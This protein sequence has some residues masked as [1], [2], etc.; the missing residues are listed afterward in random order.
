[1]TGLNKILALVLLAQMGLLAWAFWP[2]ARDNDDAAQAPLLALGQDSTSRVVISDNETGV[3][4]A[5]G[6]SGWRLPEYH[7]LPVDQ[8][9]FAR[10][11]DELPALARG[12][13]LAQTRAAKIR[14][15]VSADN[16]QRRIEYYAAEQNEGTLFLGT[17]PGFR[18]VHTRINDEDAVY[19]VEFNTFDLP[20]TAAEW[21]DKTLLQAGQLKSVQGLDYT[22]HRDGERWLDSSGDVADPAAADALSNSLGSL[23]VTAAASMDIAALL[24][25]MAV[26]PTLT[27]E[28]DSGSLEFRL[29]E[30]EEERYIKRSDIPVYFSLAAYDYDLLDNTGAA[31]LF[32]VADT[33]EA[34][35]TT[36]EP[37][38]RAS[39]EPSLPAADE[40]LSD[41]P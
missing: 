23:L 35:E 11:L 14:F 30:M 1:M 8:T 28:T 34:E 40:A 19:A 22:I 29:Y 7:D 17:S 26:P 36:T 27:V 15:E 32:P 41:T 20:T 5:R 12:W 21:L 25:D 4:L 33:A 37:A 9:R 24:E 10:V 18:K 2:A 16:F 3:A 6:E 31:S 38:A 13:P 39:A